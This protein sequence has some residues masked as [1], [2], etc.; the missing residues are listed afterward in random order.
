MNKF[1]GIG[2]LT[3]DPEL[4]TTTSGVQ[5]ARFGL[6]I[7]RKFTNSDGERETDFLNCV[8][9]RERAELLHKHCHK[10]DKIAV[11]GSVQVRQY[12]TQDGDKRTATEVVVEEINFL[13]PKGNND[14]KTPNKVDMQPI[15][16]DN[17][18]F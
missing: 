6:A 13:T 14:A 5:V 18:P 7:G 4:T 11:V 12:T 1:I 3:K 10:G 17:L 8:A 9:W 2:N 15:G 16:D